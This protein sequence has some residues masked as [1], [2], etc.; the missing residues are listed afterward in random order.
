MPS[1]PTCRL[2]DSPRAIQTDVPSKPTVLVPFK[3][4][5]PRAVKTDLPSSRQP[6]RRSTPGVAAA[7]RGRAQEVQ[8]EVPDAVAER[9]AV[10]YLS[11]HADALTPPVPPAVAAAPCGCAQ[12]VQREVTDAV[13]EGFA[14]QQLLQQLQVAMLADG[15]LTDLHKAGASIVL[16]QADKKLVDGADETLQLLDVAAQVQKVLHAAA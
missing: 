2:P 8:R 3:P 12:E 16:A 6:Q 7:P 11:S 1:K 5:A 13:A 15:A 9:F 4:T 14:A 10:P